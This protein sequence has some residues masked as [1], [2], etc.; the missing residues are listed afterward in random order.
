VKF[1]PRDIYFAVGA[2]NI[3]VLIIVY[4]DLPITVR[5]FSILPTCIILLQ[6]FTK[7]HIDTIYVLHIWASL[8]IGGTL[9]IIVSCIPLPLVSTA[10]RELTMRMSFVARQIRRE[11]TVTILLISEYHTAH[12]SDNYDNEIDRNKSKSNT[13]N[14]DE[15]EIPTTNAYCAESFYDHSTS[16][17]NL[18]D[19]HLLKSDIQDLHLLVNEEIKHMQR[20][21]TEIS[22]EP[23]FIL[24]FVLNLIKDIFRYIPFVKKIIKKPSTLQTRL[25]VWATCFASLHRT[26]TGMLSLDHH[27]AAFVGQRRLINVRTFFT[28]VKIAKQSRVIFEDII[29][30]IKC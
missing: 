17:E 21:L 15:I 8:S 7:P 24:L 19:D 12:L 18:K 11:I 14:E 10:Y 26:I 6:W 2:T 16:F 22:F 3:F 1:L 23:Y 29:Q 5:R 20:A 13:N 27:H 9:A 4:T 28:F 25:E 30:G